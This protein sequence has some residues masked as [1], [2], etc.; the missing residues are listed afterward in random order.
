MSGNIE[1]D[2]IELIF[3]RGPSKSPRA[4]AKDLWIFLNN[5][6]GLKPYVPPQKLAYSDDPIDSHSTSLKDTEPTT[7]ITESTET[8]ISQDSEL[9]PWY[10]ELCLFKRLGLDKMALATSDACC[11]YKYCKKG[12][13][14]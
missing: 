9:Y 14:T 5:Q 3:S 2:R 1:T 4:K 12:Q 11:Y 6:Q 10:N 13:Q 7:P 8:T